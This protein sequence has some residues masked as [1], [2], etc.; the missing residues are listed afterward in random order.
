MYVYLY[1]HV[2]LNFCL[3]WNICLFTFQAEKTPAGGFPNSGGLWGHCSVWQRLKPKVLYRKPVDPI[4]SK[5]GA[6]PA[7]ALHC[8]KLCGFVVKHFKHGLM[9]PFGIKN[10]K[11]TRVETSLPWPCAYGFCPNHGEIECS[12]P[13]TVLISS[14]RVL[15]CCQKKSGGCLQHPVAIIITSLLIMPGRWWLEVQRVL[16]HD[17]VEAFWWVNLVKQSVG[18]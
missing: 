14:A 13:A 5:G 1:L 6:T 2:D 3:L 16:F 12:R 15:L 7:L 18:A 17:T 11:N 4:A 9:K 10:L 8:S